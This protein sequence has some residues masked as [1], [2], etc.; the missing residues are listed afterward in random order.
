[1]STSLDYEL[2]INAMELSDLA[3][4]QT[5]HLSS[6]DLFHQLN[7]LNRSKNFIATL[8]APNLSHQNLLYLCF[9]LGLTFPTNEYILE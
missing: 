4:L 2:S 3:W 9:S 1:M 6:T 7:L 8:S 5:P